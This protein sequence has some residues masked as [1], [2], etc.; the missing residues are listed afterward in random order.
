MKWEKGRY[1]ASELTSI[2]TKNDVRVGEIIS[3]LDKYTND[4]NDVRAIG[5]CVT[6]EHATFMAE[7][8]RVFNKLY[9]RKNGDKAEKF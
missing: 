5:F 7:K 8:F 2:Y 1:V 4:I 3:N 6:I 9:R